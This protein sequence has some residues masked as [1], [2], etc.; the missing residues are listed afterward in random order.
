MSSGYFQWNGVTLP[1][2]FNVRQVANGWIVLFRDEYTEYRT[3]STF[4]FE[5]PF[6]LSIFIRDMAKQVD[7]TRARQQ[8]EL[9]KA[10]KAQTQKKASN[11]YR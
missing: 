6:D 11:P 2:T 4:V 8:R 7:R 10:A 5:N 1:P 9:K 3:D